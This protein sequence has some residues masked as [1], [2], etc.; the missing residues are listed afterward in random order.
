MCKLCRKYWLMMGTTWKIW[1][2]KFMLTA[3]NNFSTKCTQVLCSDHEDI[4]YKILHTYVHYLTIHA[5]CVR[6]W[7]T[8]AQN[9][10]VLHMQWSW[11]VYCTKYCTHDTLHYLTILYSE[12]H[13]TL[14]TL[15]QPLYSVV[16]GFWLVL[17]WEPQFPQCLVVLEAVNELV[18]SLF[19]DWDI[20][21]VEFLQWCV[22]L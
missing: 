4:L 13:S 18:N 12:R 11:E 20:T 17:L 21:Q 15:S 10:Q 14:V 1:I 2:S 9:T 7:Y 6:R 3:T 22:V 16:T 19:P 5:G 8:T